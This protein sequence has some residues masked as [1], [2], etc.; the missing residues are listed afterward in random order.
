MSKE[1]FNLEVRQA[2]NDAMR[3][4]LAEM[5]KLSRT[6]NL[7]R[8][9]KTRFAYLSQLVSSLKAGFSIDYINRA[10]AAELEQEFGK[11]NFRPSVLS[12]EAR[13]K[14]KMWR[15][16]LK[17]GMVP[18][19]RDIEGLPLAASSLN[20]NSGS[21][22]PFAWFE[23]ELPM[24]LAQADAVFSD[25]AV[26]RL[27]HT[28][29]RP[30]QIP[31]FDATDEEF[32]ATVVSENA[33]PSSFANVPNPKQVIL[34][35]KT[36]KSPMWR[37]SQESFT[38]ISDEE[39]GLTAI[40]AFERWVS[41]SLA[42]GVGRYL[43]TDANV[44]LLS[45]LATAFPQAFFAA[46]GSSANTGGGETGVNSV[47][48]EDLSTLYSALDPAYLASPKCGWW[49][50]QST[51]GYLVQLLDKQGRPLR[52]VTFNGG[53]AYIYGLPVFVSPSMQSIGA[54]NASILLMDGSMWCT[55]LALDQ[56]F[57]KVFRQAATFIES[58]DVGVR[59]FLK[60][61]GTWTLSSVGKP[62]CVALQ[63]TS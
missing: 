32:D 55:K 11:P 36:F 2:N 37:L 12:F 53:Q 20:G 28:N 63:H 7:T 18:E 44:G 22:V 6:P 47:G 40:S 29:G 39:S 10:K 23:N 48:S 19:Q 4:A 35:C 50:N 54:S 15:G 5:D 43:M 45:T 1:T 30:I 16:Y 13:Q 17:D 24:A 38:D 8:E 61:G 31:S 46:V 25:A 14:V 49:M 9:S 26:T 42:R 60:A 27:I 33:A 59:C 41:G 58:G 62:G 34:T 21:L 52:L 57:L 56:S 3:S 51:L